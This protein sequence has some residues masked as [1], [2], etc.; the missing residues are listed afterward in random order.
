MDRGS[1]VTNRSTEEGTGHVR[2][3]PWILGTAWAL[4][5]KESLTGH[6]NNKSRVVLMY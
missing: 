4:S 3:T 2:H 5:P 1:D 6:E